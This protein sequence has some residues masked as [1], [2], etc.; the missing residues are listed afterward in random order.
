LEDGG[1]QRITYVEFEVRATEALMVVTGKETLKG[2]YEYEENDN[3][4]QTILVI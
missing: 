2:H 4:P 3:C 1:G